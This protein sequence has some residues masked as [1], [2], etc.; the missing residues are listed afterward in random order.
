[1][2]LNVCFESWSEVSACENGF[3]VNSK[4]SVKTQPLRQVHVRQGSSER[5]LGPYLSNF[6]S[7]SSETF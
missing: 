2:D 5:R 3:A 7:F 6:G 1:M 4:A